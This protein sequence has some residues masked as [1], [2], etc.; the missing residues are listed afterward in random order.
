MVRDLEVEV[1]TTDVSLQSTT[2]TA[3]LHRESGM[4]ELRLRR[5]KAIIVRYRTGLLTIVGMI[6]QRLPS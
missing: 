5:L 3:G 4:R 2:M 1:R 6:G